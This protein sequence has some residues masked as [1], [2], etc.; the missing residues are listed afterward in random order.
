[1]RYRVIDKIL[2]KYIAN[3]SDTSDTVDKVGGNLLSTNAFVAPAVSFMKHRTS[4]AVTAKRVATKMKK[5]LKWQRVD[6]DAKRVQRKAV[7]PPS[8]TDSSPSYSSSDKADDAK[9]DICHPG[10]VPS[11]A[12]VTNAIGKTKSFVN[13]K[14]DRPNHTNHPPIP[15]PTTTRPTIVANGRI[16]RRTT[17]P[18]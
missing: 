15:S 5:H 1:M 12:T 2:D 13:L 17:D 4:E 9:A 16:N 7:S 18:T 14:P 8:R 3:Y 10:T 6:V 11:L